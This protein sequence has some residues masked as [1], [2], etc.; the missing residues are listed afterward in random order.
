MRPTDTLP[1]VAERRLQVAIVLFSGRLGGAEMFSAQ[2][3]AQLPQYG[4]DSHVVLIEAAGELQR[5][6]DALR[7]P[8]SVYGA[9]RG[10][11]IVYR[12]QRFARLVS[13]CGRDGAILGW[14]G[15][16]A[17]TM[18]LGGYR[19]PLIAVEHGAQLNEDRRKLPRRIYKR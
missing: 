17:A 1:A 7:V 15:Y 9:K 6:L 5:R 11:D 4:V 10:R 12:P 13:E 14:P 8:Y 16:V 19:G 18:R 3:A 2:L